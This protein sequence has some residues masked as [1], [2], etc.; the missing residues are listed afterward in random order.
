MTT[1]KNFQYESRISSITDGGG[2]T[3]GSTACD[4]ELDAD[5]MLF[6]VSSYSNFDKLGKL[7]WYLFH[8]LRGEHARKR[9]ALMTD[10]RLMKPLYL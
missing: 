5:S 2:S 7:K 9:A 10:E 6:F 1:N 3:V 8:V 4:D